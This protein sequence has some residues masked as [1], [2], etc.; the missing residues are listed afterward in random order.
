MT[1]VT[2]E[3]SYYGSAGLIKMR[4]ATNNEGNMAEKIG[5]IF[6]TLMRWKIIN[7]CV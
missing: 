5:E 1:Q 4:T 2:K 6:E 7:H 3:T